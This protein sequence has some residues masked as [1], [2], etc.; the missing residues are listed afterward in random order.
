M[1]YDCNLEKIVPI[2][3]PLVYWAGCYIPKRLCNQITN[4]K[5]RMKE[6]IYNQ[7]L[8]NQNNISTRKE[9]K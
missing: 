6:R 3:D 4:V 1:V 8:V 7:K 2:I 9:E 5:R